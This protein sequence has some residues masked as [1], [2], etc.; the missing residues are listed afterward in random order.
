MLLSLI[1]SQCNGAFG[2][3]KRVHS[4]HSLT[5]SLS[6]V[7]FQLMNRHLLRSFLREYDSLGTS[8]TPFQL[9]TRQTLSFLLLLLLLSLLFSSFHSYSIN[10]CS[11]SIVSLTRSTK[12]ISATNLLQLLMA[13][14]MYASQD[15]LQL[16]NSFLP[17]A[18]SH[19]T[20]PANNAT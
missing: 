17:L 18:A 13:C 2:R 11:L 19:A 4:L 12:N 8:E 16:D 1:S 14:A 7:N 3:A 10:L 9:V 6:Q 15:A 5:Y 20:T